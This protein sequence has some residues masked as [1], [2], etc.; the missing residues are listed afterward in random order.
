[1]TSFFLGSVLLESSKSVSPLSFIAIALWVPHTRTLQ[2]PLFMHSR[3][4]QPFKLNCILAHI[5]K[6]EKQPERILYWVQAE[7]PWG[8]RQSTGPNAS[9]FRPSHLSRSVDASASLCPGKTKHKAD[10]DLAGSHGQGS[11][12]T[13]IELTR[14]K[15]SPDEFQGFQ[16]SG[17]PPSWPG[18]LANTGES[19]CSCH[20]GFCLRTLSLNNSEYHYIPTAMANLFKK[21]DMLARKR[22]TGIL[23]Q[24]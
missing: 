19:L 4:R 24:Y 17:L 21:T 12:F 9:I 13:G 15:L 20:H 11:E 2:G 7:S 18:F 1:M 10:L 8:F 6:W 5:S 23:T 14:G 22:T 3:L 16:V